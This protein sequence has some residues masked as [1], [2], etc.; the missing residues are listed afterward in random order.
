MFTFNWLHHLPEEV[1]Y[2][3]PTRCSRTR[4][5]HALLSI[6]CPSLSVLPPPGIQKSLP[7]G[8][9][10]EAGCWRGCF[11]ALSFPSSFPPVNG[12]KC[13]AE[14][15]SLVKFNFSFDEVLPIEACF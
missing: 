13:Q 12:K 3:F 2:Q 7:P 9:S 8:T 11:L 10:L 6:E 5:L 14:G 1:N 15:I 4:R